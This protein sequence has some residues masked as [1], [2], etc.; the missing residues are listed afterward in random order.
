MAKNQ[1]KLRLVSPL[2]GSTLRTFQKTLRDYTIDPQFKKKKFFTYLIIYL[3]SP[4]RWFERAFVLPRARKKSPKE[5]V[6]I[7][8]HWRGGTTFLHNLMCQAENASFVTTFQTSFPNFMGSK[9]L[10]GPI[11]KAIMPSKRPS[12]NVKLAVDFPQEEEFALGGINPHSYYRYMYFPKHYKKYYSEATHFMGLTDDEKH[13]FVRDYKDVLHK[14]LLNKPGE[15]LVV[16]NPINTARIKFLHKEYPN[17]KWI[18]IYRNPYT[19]FRSTLKFFNELLPTLWFESVSSDFIQ[20]MILETYVK[21][22]KD[23]DAALVD[24]PGLNLVELKF[25]DFEQDPV[26]NL[27]SIY[28][29]LGLKDFEKSRSR[30]ED[31]VNSNKSYRKN[32]YEFPREMVELV[33]AHWGEYVKRWGYGVPS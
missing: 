4:F 32:E 1:F 9:W 28:D 30:F 17:A 31:Y 26:G 21:L 16:K 29:T 13:D 14:A 20:Q 25:E 10:F 18:H 23:Y 22:H 15:V 19:V 27:K 6:F 11:M 3:I 12:D 5:V 24:I 7:V 33:D 8:G 2:I